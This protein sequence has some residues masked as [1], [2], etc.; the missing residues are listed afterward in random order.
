[1]SNS[2]TRP[3]LLVNGIGSNFDAQWRRTGL[4]EKLQA[5]GRT[6]IGVDLPG[7]G[8]SRDSVGRD[9]A[10]LVADEASKHGSVD[11]IG[12]SAGGWAVL[13]A[14]SERPALFN[15]VAALGVADMVLMN[16][17][18]S[19][20]MFKPVIDALRSGQPSENPIVSVVTHITADSGNDPKGVAG[21][22][23]SSKRLIDV[24][25]LGA[26]QAQ[27]LVVE[28]GSDMAGPSSVVASS[29]PNAER[30]IVP[31]VDHFELPASEECI[32]A[33]ES[34]VTAE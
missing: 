1:M 18:A 28:G 21:F 20:S 24:P 14:A 23:E 6:V 30:V 12:F 34:F 8:G 7:H 32:A 25:G 4:V 13:L 16:G 26:I 10:D 2:D 19:D 9:A 22:L 29:I 31:G 17:V 3:I 5:A 15:R 33:V 27:V 11:A